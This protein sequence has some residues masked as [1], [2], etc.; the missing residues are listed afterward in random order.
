MADS[1]RGAVWASGHRGAAVTGDAAARPLVLV[2]PGAAYGQQA[3]L[4]WWTRA[5]AEQHGAEVVA[6]AWTVDD[7]ARTDPIAFVERAVE[8]ALEGR[9]PDLVVAKSLGC[10]AL[11]WAIRHAVSGVWLTPVL[12]NRAVASALR[13]APA[14]D[15]AIGGVADPLWQP[16]AVAGSAAQLRTVDGADHAL[17]VR[18]DWRRTQRLQADVL[19]IVDRRIADLRSD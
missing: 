14:T 7:A 4:L 12:T 10:S 6:P 16:D 11:P 9:L 3:P 17:G 15:I 13:A 1:R 5:I 18:G 19:E 2:L 8:A